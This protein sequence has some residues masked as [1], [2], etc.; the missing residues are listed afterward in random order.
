MAPA[1]AALARQLHARA[2]PAAAAAAGPAVQGAALLALAPIP[3]GAGTA[4]LVAGIAGFGL[5]H[6]MG[7]VGAAIG[8][9]AAAPPGRRGGAGAVLSTAQYLG[10]AAGPLVLG[11]PGSYASGMALG[12]ALALA[13]SAAV[14][15]VMRPAA[16]TPRARAGGRARA[17]PPRRAPPEAPPR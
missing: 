3:R 15:R 12:A 5:G 4:V 17:G 16:G 1:G 2:G 9:M 13:G 11:A 14:W 7:N 6:V 8:A 10:A